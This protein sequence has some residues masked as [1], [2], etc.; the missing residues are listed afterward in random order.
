MKEHVNPFMPSE[1]FY[2]TLSQ[3]F[4]SYTRSVWSVFKTI[5]IINYY[6]YYLYITI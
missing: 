5:I 1:L 6:Y 2:L 3:M 4:I